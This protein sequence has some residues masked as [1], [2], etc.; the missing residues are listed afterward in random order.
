MSKTKIISENI[1][2]GN[3]TATEFLGGLGDKCN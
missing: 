3:L 2:D 1:T